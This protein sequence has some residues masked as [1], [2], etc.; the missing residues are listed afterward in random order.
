MKIPQISVIVTVY[1]VGKYLRRCLDS[2]VAQTFSGF[3]CI[4]VDDCSTDS[5][6]AICDE[7]AKTDARIK[8]VHNKTNRGCPQSRKS[9]FGIAAGDYALFI[10]SDDCIEKDMLELMYNKVVTENLDMVCC[11]IYINS[12][13]RQDCFDNPVPE[14]KME[15]IKQ[16]LTF[17]KFTPSLCNKLVKHNIYEKVVFPTA[18]YGEDRP[19]SIQTIYYSKNIGFIENFLYHY[20]QND[21]SICSDNSRAQKKHIDEY[22][23]TLWSIGF[24]HKNIPGYLNQFEPELSD[25]INSVKLRFILEKSIRDLSKLHSLY[26]ESGSRIFCNTW[27]ETFINKI[28]LKLAVND[29]PQIFVLIDVFYAPLRFLKKA[30]RRIVPDRIR[31]Y[32]WQK[33]EGILPL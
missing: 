9:G 7:Y 20:Y 17:G 27:R 4:L 23:N 19:I 24:L 22:E 11:G 32:I 12:K 33:K 8:V 26:P 18:N 6:S 25:Y 28:F 29:F 13:N 30:Y 31:A 16:I 15:M 14:S 1:N 2:V 10:D 5:S 3:E 21:N